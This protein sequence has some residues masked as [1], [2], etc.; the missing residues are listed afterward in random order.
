METASRSTLTENLQ[1]LHRADL[2]ESGEESTSTAG[3]RGVRCDLRMWGLE[4]CGRW[5]Y[6]EGL[7]SAEDVI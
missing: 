7:G 6:E 4:R 5:E 3:F 2:F 1:F